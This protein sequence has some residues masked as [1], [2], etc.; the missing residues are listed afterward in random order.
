VE[1]LVEMSGFTEQQYQQLSKFKCDLDSRFTY[2]T[3]QQQYGRSEY[4]EDYD[5]IISVVE[6]NASLTSDC[7]GYA[8]AL[9]QMS[10]RAG[11]QAR[12]ILC[13]TE[14]NQGHCICEVAS[15]DMTQ[16]YY[17]DNRLIKIVSRDQLMDY[18]FYL[19]SPWNPGK[20]ETRPWS[21]VAVQDRHNQMTA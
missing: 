6:N 12:L 3:D 9:M 7:E 2:V 21:I 13:K 17:F 10:I 5:K 18:K 16:A 15:P 14:D 20:E 8:M 19:V 4:W 11:F 1:E